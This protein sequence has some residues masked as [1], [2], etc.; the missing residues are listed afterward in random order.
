MLL[1][2]NCCRKRSTVEER[3]LMM[4]AAQRSFVAAGGLLLLGWY[5][6]EGA[7]CFWEQGGLLLL[8]GGVSILLLVTINKFHINY[9]VP[10]NICLRL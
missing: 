3:S 8:E 2:V 5:S 4:L 10:Q 6:V 7:Y 9:F 1:G